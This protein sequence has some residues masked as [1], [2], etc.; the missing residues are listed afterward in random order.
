MFQ[1]QLQNILRKTLHELVN[2]GKLSLADEKRLYIVSE[3][4][5]EIPKDETHGDFASNVA[6]MIAKAAK[7][8]PRVIAE[9]IAESINE[10][11]VIDKIEIAGPG[12]LNFYLKKDYISSLINEIHKQKDTWGRCNIG[13]GK[14]ILLEFVSANPTGPLNVVNARAAT[15][16]DILGNLFDACG[17]KVDRE[18]YVND[19]GSQ[20]DNLGLSLKAR[21]FELQGEPLV[22]P[23]DGY[24]G[25]YLIDI[26]KEILDS[27]NKIDEQKW[28]DVAVSKLLEQQKG[29]LERFG[30]HFNC[31]FRQ[32]ELTANKNHLESLAK[33][34]ENG[35]VYEQDGARWFA[36]TRFGDDK[37][38]VLVR[39]TGEHTYFS[40]DIAYHFK[41][42][43]RG[44]DHLINL[45]GPD[46]HGYIPR[47]KACMQ[48]LGYPDNLLELYII[49]QVT[50]LKGGEVVKMSKRAGEFITMNDLIEE[51]GTDAARF[52][53]NLRHRDSPLEFDLDLAKSQ[54][55]ENPLYY[56][57]Y[58]HARIKSV[59]RNAREQGISLPDDMAKVNLSLLSAKE[60]TTLI[61][62]LDRFPILVRQCMEKRETHH[63][64]TYGG[65]LAR[66]FHSFYTVHRVLPATLSVVSKDLSQTRL[67]LIDAAGITIANLLGLMGVSAPDK[68]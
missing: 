15:A 10:S 35:F 5:V 32:S 36:T 8:P 54:S 44:Y 62:M 29:A 22:I 64:T 46:H 20:I 6:M 59:L 17:Y 45:L 27:G 67:A 13:N 58:A 40:V 66:A 16:G 57:Q 51:V 41:K 12:F 3:P 42:A 50:L 55:D 1:E 26:A 39:S 56:V 63:L 30:V 68:M 65:E 60:E 49:Q 9:L 4:V 33:L 52:F 7:K 47:L 34:E 53:F 14:R 21:Y 61:K 2:N 25:L 43:E 18:Y 24:N 28:S 48:A 37:D 19:E 11:N 23:A 31:F 38:R